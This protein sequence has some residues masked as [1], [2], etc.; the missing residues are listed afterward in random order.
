MGDV[1]YQEAL[2]LGKRD[3]K[4]RVFEGQFPY[5][6]VLDEILSEA[7]IQTEQNM[8]LV[9]VPL[10]LVVGTSTMGRTYSFASNFMPILDESSEFAIKWANL[11]D[12]Q[13]NEGIR[14]PIK[15]Y[16]YMNRYYVVEG[17]KRASVLKYYKAV[18]IA[19]YVTRKIPKYSEDKEIKLY[20]EYMKFNE[21]TG[22]FT[23][24]FSKLGMAEQLLT[25]IGKTT[26]WD[27]MDRENFNKVLFDFTK[28]FNFR[29]GQR[30]RIKL[31]DAITSF[32]NIFG[33]EKM[34]SMTESEYNDNILRVWNE[35][36]M[37]QEKHSVDLVMDP[38]KVQEKHSILKSLI[39]TMPKKFT[40]AFLYPKSP[41]TSDWI[42][43][44]DLGC[45]YLGRF[46]HNYNN[47]KQIQLHHLY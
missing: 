20:Y 36:T 15:A 1:E 25:L 8:G 13:V 32:M 11:A 47:R 5:L 26:R 41:D 38:T 6:P 34:Y 2:K 4:A 18:S 7:D 39:P 21:I 24:E 12:A 22:L 33:Y 29:G 37:L 19:A 42:Y 17:N 28:A 27:D 3:Y 46:H 14:D 31:G 44:H 9:Q 23:V 40:V 16:E 45:N 30:L 43:A 35:F 10:D